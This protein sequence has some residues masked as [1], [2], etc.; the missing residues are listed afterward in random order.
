[1]LVWVFQ[2]LCVRQPAHLAWRSVAWTHCDVVARVWHGVVA[3]SPAPLM[4]NYI[5][6][7]SRTHNLTH[8]EKQG[9]SKAKY[10]HKHLQASCF[11]THR[12][13]SW[14]GVSAAWGST[15][16]LWLFYP[17]PAT[18]VA[19]GF[20]SQPGRSY[21]SQRSLQNSHDTCCKSYQFSCSDARSSL[22]HSWDMSLRLRKRPMV[23]H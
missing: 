3:T 5:P 23:K 6:E 9:C 14:P 1:M 12:A 2:A 18:T 19:A 10:K 15:C 8:R 13:Y 16:F 22:P 20:S 11:A 4:F 21:C 17:S 7:K